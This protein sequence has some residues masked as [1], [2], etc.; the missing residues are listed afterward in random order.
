MAQWAKVLSAKNDPLSSISGTYMIDYKNQLHG[1]L[2]SYIYIPWHW[3]KLTSLHTQHTHK[4]NKK[5]K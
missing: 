3:C 4:R 5:I 1:L 2:L